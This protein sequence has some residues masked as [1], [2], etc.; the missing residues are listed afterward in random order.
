MPW[1]CPV[2]DPGTAFSWT[3]TWPEAPGSHSQPGR[4]GPK[5]EFSAS[6]VDSRSVHPSKSPALQR[7]SHLTSNR[8]QSPETV[9]YSLN[10]VRTARIKQ[11]R[12][13]RNLERKKERD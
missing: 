6:A 9:S 4:A 1:G 8:S 5:D 3:W 7:F 12:T 10:V 11:P 2:T 13:I